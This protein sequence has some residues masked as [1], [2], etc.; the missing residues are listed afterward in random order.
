MLKGRRVDY[1]LHV[2]ATKVN[3]F[4]LYRRHCKVSGFKHNLV[5]ADQARS[6]VQNAKAIPVDRVQL[7]TSA[8]VAALIKNE[9]GEVH[10]IQ[11]PGSSILSFGQGLAVPS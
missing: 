2:L 5:L 3:T 9:Q 10:K 7:P 1:H 8:G 4:F 6:T 11:F